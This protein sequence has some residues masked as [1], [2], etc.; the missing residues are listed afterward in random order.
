MDNQKEELSYFRLHL[1]ELLET[2]F[3]KKTKDKTFISQ[4]AQRAANAY[5]GAFLAG[6]TIY[7]Q[8]F[9]Q[10]FVAIFLEK[11]LPRFFQDDFVR[12]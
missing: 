7:N 9:K 5:E 12:F 11:K 1:L 6:I 10:Y 4:R 3:P 8:L 2:S